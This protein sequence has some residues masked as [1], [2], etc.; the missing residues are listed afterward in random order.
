[1]YKIIC[2]IGKSGSGKST[3]EQKLCSDLEINQVVSHT[4]RPPRKEELDGLDYFFCTD[5]YFEEERENFIEQRLYKVI[6]KDGTK[7]IWRYG[8]HRNSI[9][10]GLNV[11]VVDVNGYKALRKYFGKQNVLPFFIHCSDSTRLNRVLLRGDGSNKLEVMRRFAADEEAFY[12]IE[13]NKDIYKICNEYSVDIAVN[14]IINIL[15]RLGI[16]NETY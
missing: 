5:D 12:D 1:M 11:V 14:E 7:G 8:L 9:K 10:E 6:N 16:V 15:K 3:I 13:H 4:T 2:L